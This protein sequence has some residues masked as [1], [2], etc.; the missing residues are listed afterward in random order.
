MKRG[1]GE[2]KVIKNESDLL[3]GGDCSNA[4]VIEKYYLVILN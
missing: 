1:F 3:S 2:R 4:K